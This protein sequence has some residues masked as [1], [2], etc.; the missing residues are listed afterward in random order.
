[1]IAVERCEWNDTPAPVRQRL[2]ESSALAAD[3][4][5][6]RWTHQ[7]GKPV[8]WLAHESGNSIAA[9]AGVEFHPRPVRRFQS[10]PNNLAAATWV[11]S[12]HG[13]S[14]GIAATLRAIR[15]ASYSRAWITDYD[16]RLHPADHWQKRELY[17][18]LATLTGPDWLPDD[19]AL[20]R[21]VRAAERGEV[22]VVDFTWTQHSEPFL[23]LCRESE[24]RQKR[25]LPYTME[26]FRSLSEN[27]GT[28]PSIL[29]LAGI[30]DGKL[31]A[32]QIYLVD[33]QVALYWQ[34]FL[35][36]DYARTRVSQLLIVTAARQLWP[37][38]VTRL[39]L[40]LSPAGVESLEQ[41]KARWGVT[42]HAYAE[43]HYRSWLG[44]FV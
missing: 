42:R 27:A 15:R 6:H 14:G 28:D 34:A 1:M 31:A 22:Q 40:G 35:D 37:R 43:Y 21:Q 38:G 19:D 23:Q 33:R 30:V 17:V 5:M 10:L 2:T 25:R 13:E 36:R 26:F 29:W 7:G 9:V 11:A 16:N 8:V 41:Y 44:R 3:A 20:V 12:G 32:T 24:S 4:W 18:W 39:N